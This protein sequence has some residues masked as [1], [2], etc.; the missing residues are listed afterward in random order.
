MAEV[1][2]GGDVRSGEPRIEGTRVT[3]LDVKR[4]VLDAGED[5]HVVASEYDL[6]GGGL[7]RAL[8]Y[9]HDNREEFRRLEEEHAAAR[10]AGERATRES[11]AE[12]AGA[13]EPPD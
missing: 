8:A 11:L 6:P 2:T 9:Y 7:F 12:V 1:V 4:R 3:V 13:E 5:P 10:A